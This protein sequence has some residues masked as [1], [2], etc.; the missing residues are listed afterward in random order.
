MVRKDWLATKTVRPHGAVTASTRCSEIPADPSL[1]TMECELFRHRPSL[2]GGCIYSVLGLGLGLDGVIELPVV[3]CDGNDGY[4]QDEH[5]HD[6]I[7]LGTRHGS[8]DDGG[9]CRKSEHLALGETILSMGLVECDAGDHDD[10]DGDTG[11]SRPVDDEQVHD[12]A[13]DSAGTG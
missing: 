8:P 6:G 13:G 1:T 11:P 4:N 2:A 10:E 7:S 12:G 3:G 9:G 5:V